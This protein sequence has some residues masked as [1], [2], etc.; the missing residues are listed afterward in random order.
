[1]KFSQIFF[2]D[3]MLK[4]VFLLHFKQVENSV[5]KLKIELVRKEMTIFGYCIILS[6][7][8]IYKVFAFCIQ[9]NPL[10]IIDV[11]FLLPLILL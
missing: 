6:F 7:Y 3:H 2:T 11:N 8:G 9:E 1:M 10:Y 5:S 4:P